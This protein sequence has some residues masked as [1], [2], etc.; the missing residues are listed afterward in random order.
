[1][2]IPDAQGPHEPGRLTHREQ[3]ILAGIATDLSTDPAL[4][5]QLREL[6]RARPPITLSRIVL[7]VPELLLLALVGTAVPAEWSAALGPLTLLLVV[8]WVILCAR[9]SARSDPDASTSGPT[10]R[11]AAR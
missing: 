1:M 4:S 10:G 3:E 2:S 11:S 6:G 9:D 8:P 7:L 5:R